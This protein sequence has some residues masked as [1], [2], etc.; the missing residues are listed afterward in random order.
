M[1][2]KITSLLLVLVMLLPAIVSCSEKPKGESNNSGNSDS[3]DTSTPE[4]SEPNI[5]DGLNFDGKEFRIQMSATDISSDDYMHGSDELTG[6]VVN[7][8]VYSRNMAV[9]ERLGVK[10][11]YSDSNYNWNEVTTQI[12]NLVYA[13]T[14]DFELIVN[15]QLGMSTASIEKLL[16]NAYDC[17]YFDF[18]QPY[19]WNSY[20]KDL[21][22]TN[23]SMY[24]LVG[25][26][27]ID[28]L[29]KSHVIY[30]NRNLYTDLFG[31]P[32]ELYKTVI[33]GK[34]TYDVFLKYID[35]SYSDLNGN[36]KPDADDRYGMVIGG[37]G[38]SIFPF[39]YSS[40]T[41]F[42]SRDADG[43]PSLSMDNERMVQLYEKVYRTYY[44]EG[45]RTNYTENGTDLH[46][47]F[48]S[49]TALFINT[50]SIGDFDVFRDMADDIGLVPYPKLDE[51]QK[52][53]ITVIHDTA[54]V[55][56]IPTTCQNIDFASAVI[57]AL[58]EETYKTVIPAYYETAL[59]I[60]YVR[61]DYTAQMIDLVHDG[62]IGLFT[63]V[64]GADWANNIFTWTF[65]EPLQAKNESCIS[66]YASREA[67]AIKGLENLIT[68]YMAN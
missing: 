32:D 26:Y 15:D 28:V 8:A 55:G 68:T 29:R 35:E 52:E 64:Y 61:D 56:A 2:K 41:K 18:E 34:W 63:L 30:Y 9:E 24:L 21:S 60:K 20:M 42:I 13:G 27:F 58:C 22:V 23:K 43:I 67:A 25:D 16:V 1:K 62:I 3:S 45:T 7:D 4:T 65:L 10:L 50:A 14:D 51:N 54:E 40:D 5:L 12:R 47:K 66:S 6:D 38:G 59:K 57:Q 53:Y 33:D 17:A 11:T 36:G 49:G 46:T 31:D 48:A 37:V 39:I 19:W 44:S